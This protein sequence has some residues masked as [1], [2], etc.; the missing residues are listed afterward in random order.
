ME[1]CERPNRYLGEH[2]AAC[3]WQSQSL[4]GAAWALAVSN[5]DQPY[6]QANVLLPRAL[7]ECLLR[8]PGASQGWEWCLIH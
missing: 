5:I 4:Q 8:E 6:C 3:C 7:A 1:N 2:L